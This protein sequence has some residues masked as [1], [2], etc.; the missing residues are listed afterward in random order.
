MLGCP[1]AEDPV[2]VLGPIESRGH[3]RNAF[4]SPGSSPSNH[5]ASHHPHVRGPTRL[6]IGAR[7]PRTPHPRHRLSARRSPRGAR[8]AGHLGEGAG[9]RPARLH[10][11]GLEGER[12][13]RTHRRPAHRDGA[14]PDV[15]R[16]RR[17]LALSH[18]A[19]AVGQRLDL[20]PQR[21]PLP[22]RQDVR[23][24][25]RCVLQPRHRAVA[26]RFRGRMEPHR[27]LRHRHRHRRRDG[28]I[29]ARLSLVQRTD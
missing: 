20:E 25:H 29:D 18:D 24:L 28:G 26:V 22:L 12:V 14:R 9:R 19:L 13:V 5:P 15:L 17:H 2:F 3:R 10:V 11:D 8:A 7:P 1:R 23:G 16:E 21:Q 4:P 6:G 27:C